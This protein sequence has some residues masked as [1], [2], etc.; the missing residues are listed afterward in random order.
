MFNQTHMTRQPDIS[1]C[2]P[3]TCEETTRHTVTAQPD[4]HDQ[5]TSHIL[6]YKQ[7]HVTR[8]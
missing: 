4:T 3:D 5:T 2:K 6:E 1:H 8:E 7:T